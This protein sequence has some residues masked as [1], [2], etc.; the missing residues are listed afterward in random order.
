MSQ[1]R[2]S[3]ELPIPAMSAVPVYHEH[4]QQHHLSA[5]HKEFMEALDDDAM[6]E[7]S[8]ITLLRKLKQKRTADTNT[9]DL[10]AGA[11]RGNEADHEDKPGDKVESKLGGLTAPTGSETLGFPAPPGLAAPA[12]SGSPPTILLPVHEF[13]QSSSSTSASDIQ[14]NSRASAWMPTLKNLP[15][16]GS[17]GSSDRSFSMLSDTSKTSTNSKVAQIQL[18][19]NRLLLSCQ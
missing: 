6:D 15:S 18:V 14:S 1:N 11:D 16:K 7:Q 2:L 9:S 19:N 12:A 5:G 13:G 17:D 10:R 3:T 4:S 8:M